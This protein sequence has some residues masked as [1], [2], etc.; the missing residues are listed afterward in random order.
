M[1]SEVG[2]DPCVVGVRLGRVG[3]RVCMGELTLPSGRDCGVGGGGDEILGCILAWLPLAFIVAER[4]GGGRLGLVFGISSW[5]DICCS[6]AETKDAG[7]DGSS[8]LPIDKEVD[9]RRRNEVDRERSAD[10][11]R[12]DRDPRFGGG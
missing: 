12:V 5:S 1:V 9:S 11:G 3:S 10:L 8:L 2:D 7:D 4:L 6:L